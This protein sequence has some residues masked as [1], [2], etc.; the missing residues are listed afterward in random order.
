MK[1][2]IKPEIKCVT[3]QAEMGYAMSQG[4]KNNFGRIN[5]YDF[6]SDEFDLKKGTR[7]KGYLEGD[8]SDWD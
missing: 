2:Y 8:N 3:F 5:E 6:D 1:K 7:F 4:M